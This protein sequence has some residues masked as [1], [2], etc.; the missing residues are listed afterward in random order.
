MARVWKDTKMLALDWTQSDGSAAAGIPDL[1]PPNPRSSLKVTLDFT[2]PG[3]GGPRK[4]YP[5][6]GVFPDCCQPEHLAATGS[7]IWYGTHKGTH[8][9]SHQ[10]VNACPSLS[11]VLGACSC[12][13]FPLLETEV[14]MWSVFS[15]SH[16]AQGHPQWV[17]RSLRT[18]H[19][20]EF[21]CT[22]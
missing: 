6:P 20:Q 18:E 3:P 21:Q 8:H 17:S 13:P 19:V 2:V 1:S 16:Q 14:G 15:P 22:R 12:L 10:I 7:P 9:T 4:L 11:C 5:L